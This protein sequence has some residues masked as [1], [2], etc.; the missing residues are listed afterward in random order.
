MK[1]TI[2]SG[3][4]RKGEEAIRRDLLLDQAMQLFAEHGYGNLSLETI[5]RKA[6]VSLRTIYAQFG[7]KAE[8]FGAVIRRL[9]DEFEA[10]LP[11]DEA[12]SRPVDEIL[13]EFGRLYLRRISRPDCAR[14]RTQILAEAHRFPE[15]AAEFY[16]NGPERTLLRLTEFFSARQQAGGLIEEDCR[17]LAGQ[18]LNTL[19]G[20]RFQRQQL[21]LEEPLSEEEAEAWA[22]QAVQLF[23]RGCLKRQ[24]SLPVSTMS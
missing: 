13:V 11:P 7:G 10:S 18:F 9:S 4:P 17:F 20:E 15:L 5:A 23:L 12:L 3:R 8:L 6:R 21:G 2:R 22:R 1:T 14:L 19:R 24:D 16:R